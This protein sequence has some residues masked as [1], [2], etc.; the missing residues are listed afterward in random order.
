MKRL[1]LLFTSILFLNFSFGQGNALDFDGSNEYVTTSYSGV[2]GTNPR[3]VEAWIQISASGGNTI[4]SYGTNGAGEKWSFRVSDE[5]LLIGSSVGFMQTSGANVND[6]S[7]HHVAVT[8]ASGNIED[9]V[10]YIDAVKQTS[11]TVS[12]GSTT[13]NT[14]ISNLFIGRDISTAGDFTG[15]IDE[16]RVWN[17]ALTESQILS[18]YNKTYTSATNL[19]SCLELYYKFDESSGTSAS[20]DSGNSNTGTLTN[21]DGSTDWVAS[22]AGVSSLAA[23]DCQTTTWTGAVDNNWATAGNWDFGI[24]NANMF[25]SIGVGGTVIIDAVTNALAQR[26]TMSGDLTIN[27]ELTIANAPTNGLQIGQSGSLVNNNTLNINSSGSN[28]IEF[29]SSSNGNSVNNTGTININNSQEEGIESNTAPTFSLTNSGTINI[30]NTGLGGS[31]GEGLDLRNTVTF[32]NS[33]DINLSNIGAGEN[34]LLFLGGS[35]SSLSNTG[36]IVL[37]NS[38]SALAFINF[39]NSVDFQNSGTLRCENEITYTSGSSAGAVINQSGGFIQGLG[40]IIP[41]AFS[42]AGG[43]LSPGL[44]SG[45]LAFDASEDFSNAILNIEINGTAGAGIVGGHDQI[46]VNGTPSLGGTA[47]LNVTNGYTPTNGD[48]VVILDGTSNVTGI[49]SGSSALN[50]WFINYNTPNAGDITLSFGAILPVELLSFSAK[51]KEDKVLLDWHTSSELNNEGFDIERST[52][53]RVWEPLGFLNGHGTTLDE[54]FYAFIDEKP[55]RGI[56]YYRLRQMD[57]DGTW[58]FSEVVSVQ[59]LQDESSELLVFPNPIDNGAL[60][61]QFPTEMDQATLTLFGSAGQIIDRRMVSGEQAFMDFSNYPKGLYLIQLE[62]GNA[63]W[64]ERLSV[65]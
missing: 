37:S 63:R 58:E 18:I 55:A 56:N 27:G 3:T 32:S 10:L 41:S 60:T 21:M 4:L 17:K 22:G 23:V 11:I 28:G 30:T 33:G 1:L 19:M 34:G 44:S 59:Y 42:N 25:A 47:V 49:F 15:T 61:I 52:D 57:F 31:D 39:D 50:G 65:Q 36:N 45:I 46:T 53:G 12:S 20:D 51:Q 62:K 8:W 64:Q 6:G 40:T 9:A 14:G 24:P 54:Q 43:T 29:S 16:V 26:V 48:E 35:G 38:P 13:I 7:W 5:E 2:T